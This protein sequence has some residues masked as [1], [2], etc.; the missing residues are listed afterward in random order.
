MLAHRQ[1]GPE[2]VKLGADA[3]RLA[4]ASHLGAD[5]FAVDHGVAAG[6]VE[7]AGEHADRRGLPRAVVSEKRGDL[8]G[9]EG[10]GEVVYGDDPV[11]KL[12]LQASNLDRRLT[13]LVVGEGLEVLA[14]F[15]RL[16]ARRAVVVDVVRLAEP[17]LLGK[18]EKR[19]ELLAKL[20]G[21][22][23][24]E[25]PR[26]QRVQHAVQEH[27]ANDG[28]RGEV[29]VLVQV[30]IRGFERDP[31]LRELQTREYVPPH[32]DGGARQQTSGEPARAALRGHD[33]HRDRRRDGHDV[34]EA[35]HD[36]RGDASAEHRGYHVVPQDA[37]RDPERVEHQ[38]Q[39]R[40]RI[41]ERVHADNHDENHGAHRREEVGVEPRQPVHVRRH[42]HHL[43]PLPQAQLFLHDDGLHDDHHV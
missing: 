11:A 42:S 24:V 23:F 18:R 28:R 3:Q 8:A 43:H 25:V 34:H 38:L 41:L 16:L 9:D 15:G 17:V 37:A 10:H 4:N 20:C 30:L 27:H 5:G 6:G 22:N 29:A 14:E 40:I 12:L 35:S 1:R 21:P 26:H 33:A 13:Q 7:G 19:A 32:V 39:E 2:D 36:A 31:F